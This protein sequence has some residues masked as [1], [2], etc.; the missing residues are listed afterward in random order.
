MFPGTSVAAYAA[1][2]VRKDSNLRISE[3][4]CVAAARVDVYLSSEDTVGTS[5]AAYPYARSDL[6]QWFW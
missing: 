1:L 5:I 2:A 3:K 4:S 6:G